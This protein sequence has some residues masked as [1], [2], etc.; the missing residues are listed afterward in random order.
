MSHDMVDKL[1]RQHG[2]HLPWYQQYAHYLN[3]LFHGDLGTSL[4]YEGRP[5]L[6]MIKNSLSISL[7][8]GCQGLL[9]SIIMGILIGSCTALMRPSWKQKGLTL[10]S[11]IG[12]SLPSFIIATLLQ[13]VLAVKWNL[14]PIARWGSFTHTILPTLALSIFPAS[15]IA[16]LTR[17]HMESLKDKEFL[18]AARAKG[19]PPHKLVIKHMLRNTL[20]PLTTYLA[21]ITTHLLT[22]SFVI[23]KIFSLPGFGACMVS[24]ISQRDYPVIAGTTLIYA[25]IL[26]GNILLV[27]ILYAFIDPRISLNPFRRVR[28]PPLSP[29]PQLSHVL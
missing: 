3:G 18:V 20:L 4:R 7:I 6:A 13:Y 21:P 17:A 25:T 19:L 2:L 29:S 26:M 15:G 23:E 22:G 28:K 24:S 1:S 16:K 5:V 8:L 11:L 9:F 10:L 14:L 27:D 12:T